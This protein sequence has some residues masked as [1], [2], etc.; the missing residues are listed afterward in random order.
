[1]EDRHVTEFIRDIKAAQAETS[2][3]IVGD[4]C[5][6]R[7][8][9]RIGLC[10]LGVCRRSLKVRDDPEH[11]PSGKSLRML[12]QETQTPSLLQTSSSASYEGSHF[13]S[14]GTCV[15]QNCLPG[16]TP[17]SLIQVQ[18]S[19][20]LLNPMSKSINSADICAYV[21]A[22]STFVVIRAGGQ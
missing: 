22:I 18:M 3:N 12:E 13:N 16:F 19:R 1:V 9:Q 6:D 4:D 5:A 21:L 14:N 10:Q 7:C 11:E 2:P 17:L 20:L 8:G 15:S